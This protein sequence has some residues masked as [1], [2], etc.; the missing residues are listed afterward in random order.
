MTRS[1]R[2]FFASV[3]PATTSAAIAEVGTRQNSTRMRVLMLFLTLGCIAI[4]AAT[5]SGQ[6]VKYDVLEVE[7][8]IDDN[9]KLV[10]REARTY[11]T[12]RD[13]STIAPNRAATVQRYFQQYVPA[14]ITQPDSMYLI[15]DL[16]GHARSTL[17]SA[18]RSQTPG[19]RNVMRW[20]Y[21]GLK[22]VA[23]GNYHPAARINAIQFIA[24]LSAPPTQRGGL[25]VP[26]PFVLTDMKEIY[27]NPSN[28][29]AVRAAA[30]QGLERYV[31]YTSPTDPRLQAAKADLTQAMTQLLESEAP[32]GRDKLAHAFLQRYAVNILTNLSTDASLAKQLVNISTNEANPDLIALHSAAAIAQLPGKMAE[33][34]VETKEVLKQWSKR[35]LD[36]YQSELD[37][38][39]KLEK[40]G[41]TMTTQPAPPE[42]YLKETKDPNEKVAGRT[43]MGAGMA[44]MYS[45]DDDMYDGM[46]QEM[47]MME[48]M[49]GMGAM[50]GMSG[51]GMTMAVEAPQP[52]EVVASRRKL[53]YALQQVVI[54]VTGKGKTVED[55]DSIQA[56]SGLLAST[57]ADSLDATKQW[58]KSVFELTTQLNDKTLSTRRNYITALESQVEALT[59]LSKGESATVK[60]LTFEDPL[61]L[62][63]PL[64][65]LFGNPAAEPA[66]DA[67]AEGAAEGEAPAKPA[68]AVPGLD[69]LLN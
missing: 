38:L 12:S 24:N 42:S 21:A 66:A 10:Q 11:A 17:Q 34:D 23:V 39:A 2:D 31:R 36:A 3:P 15:N 32:A 28:P 14:K 25:P 69:A 46:D 37:R 56:T 20:L 49:Q 30:L 26:Y 4:L 62:E 44:D 9:M 64:G 8:A 35:V 59:A 13:I 51:G 29:D 53:N 65:G 54:G 6:G 40:A 33:G 52:P 48:M 1:Q 63:N 7:K 45:M 22:P 19:A 67:A 55:V 43:M 50:S 16:M 57:P 5:A 60:A 27:D 68:E 41:P 18:V 61:G 47:D 58:L